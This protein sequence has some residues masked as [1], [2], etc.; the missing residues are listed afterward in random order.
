MTGYPIAWDYEAADALPD[1]DARGPYSAAEM[2]KYLIGCH[3]HYSVEEPL[4]QL[5]EPMFRAELDTR[6]RHF[7]L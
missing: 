3:Y 6:D 2:T 4:L 1:A 7:W 5:G